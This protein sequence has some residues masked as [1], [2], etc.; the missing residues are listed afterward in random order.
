MKFELSLL[1]NSHDYI[2]NSFD[3]YKIADEYGTHDEQRAV[4]ENKVKWKLAFVTMVQAF[5]LLLKEVLYRIHPKLI[6][7]NIDTENIT[8]KNT[9]SFRHALIRIKNFTNF[10]IENEDKLFL[11]NCLKLRNAF[12]HHK[13]N[14]QSE[15]IKSKYCKLYSLYTKWHSILLMKILDSIIASIKIQNMKFL[16]MTK[17]G[18]FSGEERLEK[19][20]WR[21]LKRR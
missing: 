20:I 12:I 8:E 19:M 1:Q 9:I 17:T 14:I 3:L 15:Q 7:E 11:I 2:N 4:F 6:Y 18:L 5:E 16:H 21:S 10:S 13:V